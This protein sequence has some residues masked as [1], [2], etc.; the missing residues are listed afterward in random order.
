MSIALI[1]H[2]LELSHTDIV[3]FTH[4]APN[5]VWKIYYQDGFGLDLIHTD[6]ENNGLFIEDFSNKRAYLSFLKEN[7]R[8]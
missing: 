3:G 8:K 2:S 7:K 6:K 4:C 1:I 5:T